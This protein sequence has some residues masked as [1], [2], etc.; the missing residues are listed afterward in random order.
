ME[1]ISYSPDALSSLMFHLL[2]ALNGR[3][4]VVI[5]GEM[6]AG[7]TTLVKSFCEHLGVV[8]NTGSPTY[9]LVNEYSYRDSQGQE[10]LFHHLD[11]Y[12]L[13]SSQEA[14]DIGIEDLLY[15]RWYCFIEWP[16]LIEPMLP[17]DAA[18]IYIE[19]VGE[20]TRRIKIV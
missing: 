14:L 4:K 3:K 1:L 7:K 20:N 8:E 16:E 6:G 9:S 19:T 18:R 5:Y 15:D 17:T 13:Q 12:R 10:A 11:L 2:D